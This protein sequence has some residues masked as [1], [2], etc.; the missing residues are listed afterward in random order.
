MEER[1]NGLLYCSNCGEKTQDK[2][3]ECNSCGKRW[4]YNSKGFQVSLKSLMKSPRVWIPF[5]ISFLIVIAIVQW[6]ESP[7]TIDFALSRDSEKT[8]NYTDTFTL[9]QPMYYSFSWMGEG[10]A[11]QITLEKIEG[12]E[13]SIYTTRSIQIP[14]NLLSETKISGETIAPAEPGTYNMKL[15]NLKEDWLI[16]EGEFTVVE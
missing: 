3:I 13:S 1:Q 8:S 9:N 2:A 10:D 6:L 15:L 12:N 14:E 11:V 7:A 16:G 5:I 4:S